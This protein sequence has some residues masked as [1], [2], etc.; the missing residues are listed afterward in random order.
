[1]VKVV[2]GEKDQADDGID[3]D[4]QQSMP[5]ISTGPDGNR[6]GAEGP[7]GSLPLR[8][9]VFQPF[10]LSSVVSFGSSF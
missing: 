3:A 1:M 2:D 6:R 4:N 5:V 7:N 8:G 10:H 9:Q